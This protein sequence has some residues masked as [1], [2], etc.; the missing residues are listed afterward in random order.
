MSLWVVVVFF[1][2]Y[3]ML[4]L[5]L[6]RLRAELGPP[7]NE[8]YNIGPDQMLPKIFGTRF[9]GTRNLTMFAM[10]WG[11]NR[12]HRCNPM[13]YQLEGLKITD[14][15]QIKPYRLILA[16]ILACGVGLWIG[17]W[18]FLHV[19]YKDGFSGGFGWEAYRHLQQWVYY[20]PDADGVATIFMGIGFNIVVI[21]TFL[22]QRFLWWTLHPAAYPL[23]TSM[24]WTMGWLWSS[25]CTSWLLKWIILKQGGFKAY[26][27][28]IPFFF[29]LILGDYLVGG[30]W[31]VWGILSHRYI[32]TFWH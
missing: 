7:V 31:N 2:F 29:G 5:A 30:I 1:T 16:M 21:L 8:L 13:P 24:G 3:F 23:A 14:R 15:L 10:F 22:R 28:A 11:F 26:R 18:G 27:R 9:I 17:F 32:Y 4:V 12:A 20:M 25:I 6:T 19:H